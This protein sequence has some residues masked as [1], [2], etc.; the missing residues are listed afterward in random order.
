MARNIVRR[1][2]VEKLKAVSGVKAD[3]IMIERMDNKS[4]P[5]GAE[6]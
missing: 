5:S 1:P 3:G 4:A 6:S 2:C